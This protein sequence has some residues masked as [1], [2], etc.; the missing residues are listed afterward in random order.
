MIVQNSSVKGDKRKVFVFFIESKY[1][2]VVQSGKKLQVRNLEQG[3]RLANLLFS[4]DNPA[5]SMNNIHAY[6]GPVHSIP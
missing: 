3:R 2:Y 5:M 4:E 1:A 6:Q